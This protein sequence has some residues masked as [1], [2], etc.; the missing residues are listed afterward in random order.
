MLLSL[1]VDDAYTHE[2]GAMNVEIVLLVVGLRLWRALGRRPRP[3]V[4]ALACAGALLA[5]SAGIADLDFL[6]CGGCLRPRCPHT[7]HAGSL[8]VG[9]SIVTICTYVGL[10]F[11]LPRPPVEPVAIALRRRAR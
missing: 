7:T 8:L 6:D 10:L 3:I 2:L 11:P 1:C 5:L 4:I 9:A